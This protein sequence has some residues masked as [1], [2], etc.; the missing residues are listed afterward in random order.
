[1]TKVLIIGG[2][3]MIGQKIASQLASQGLEGKTVSRVTLLDRA[4]PSNGAAHDK[5][6]IGSLGDAAL[7][8]EA[9]NDRPDIIFQL[10]AI[11]SG[12]AEQKFA[13]GWQINVQDMWALLELV[14]QANLDEGYCPRFVFASSAAVYGGPMPDV[15]SDEHHCTPQS[16]YG[17][18]K[19]IGE[20]YV[21]EFSRKGFINGVSLRLPTITV[22][23]G[24]PNAAL[25]SCFSGIIR[26]PL[27]GQEAILPLP[28]STLHMHASP[29]SAAGFFRHAAVL[30]TDLLNGVRA[31]VPPSISCTI[32]EQIDVLKAHAGNDVVKLIKPQQNP[33][34]AKMVE[35]WP[36]V[37]DASR[38]RK[39]GFTSEGSFTE[40]LNVY[41][42]EDF[43]ES[44]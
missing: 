7:R 44:T 5:A 12:E 42:E 1:M 8:A 26:E 43:V 28:T 34:I 35:G 25:S 33:Q 31:L 20:M 41:L 39:L 9:V 36:K 11:V 30:D 22:R 23:P 38:A 6:L 10:A 24:A 29:R 14:R 21:N 18:H 4:I 3:G 2:G 13:H 37:F 19:V 27:N 32:E 17:V 15:I 16:S 40:I